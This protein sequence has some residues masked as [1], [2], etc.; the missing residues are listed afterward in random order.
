MKIVICGGY[1]AADF[2]IK[3]FKGRQHKLIVINDSRDHAKYLTKNNQ[4]P[5]FH[6]EFWKKS[7]LEDTH[8]DGSDL[9]IA[10]GYKDCDNF[11]ACLMA[12]KM[13]N[14][15]K[16]ICI[17]NN[18]KNVDIF[19]ELGVESVIS[20]TQLLAFSILSESSL[21]NLIKAV[22]IED[23][24]IVMTE[25]VIKDNYEIAH[26]KIMDISFPKTGNISCIYRRP[27]VIIPNGSTLILPKDKLAFVSTP[28]NQKE[29]I[30]FIQRV[31]KD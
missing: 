8:I 2:I 20:S 14:V 27:N 13:F 22:S 11:V 7:V 28:Q 31:K 1:H 6:G 16:C 10:L 5:V 15:K 4:I 18:P 25:I 23:D 17:V 29:I 24:K 19:R 26:K 21:E 3:T 9:F 12:K 30:N